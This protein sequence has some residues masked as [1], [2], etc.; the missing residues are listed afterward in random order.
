MKL[1][2]SQN[3]AIQL[4]VDKKLSLI[5]GSAGS[6]KTTLIAKLKK[7]LNRASIV[8]PTGKGAARIKQATGCQ[9]T[10]IHRLL[11]Y[12]GIGYQREHLHGVSLICDESSMIDLDLMYQIVSRRPE[13]LVLIGDPC[14]LLPVGPGAPFHDLLKFKRENVVELRFNYRNKEAIYKA[15]T[16]IRNKN[17][18]EFNTRT[19]NE[20]WKI[21]TVGDARQTQAKIV[22]LV[23]QGR[24][25]FDHDIIICCRNGETDQD[26]CTVRTLN[27]AIIEIV[28]KRESDAKWQ[29][30]DRIMLI[31]NFAEFDVYNGDT[32]KITDIDIDGNLWVELDRVICDNE[33][34]E[35][36]SNIMF[37]IEM[38][39]H[40][41]HAYALT[42]HKAQG[43]Q[44]RTVIFACLMRDMS[45][46]LTNNLIY[47]AVTRAQK[48]CLVI[49][50]SKAFISG[51]QR[52]QQRSTIIQQ[53]AKGD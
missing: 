20:T 41:V 8:C 47:T 14:Q 24:I 2:E 27:N 6:G 39:K 37:D 33:G 22:S 45:M 7:E 5:T 31:K 43:S 18:P 26:Y 34:K 30:N 50:Q 23:K 46:M 10:T 9:A 40:C 29:V 38:K 49:G 3:E 13:K 1:D 36:S 25:D 15:A 51:I 52:D 4:A 17:T 21:L 32:G 48:N 53:L 42:T 12:D 16:E 35:I 11:K 28:N 19:D 44:Y